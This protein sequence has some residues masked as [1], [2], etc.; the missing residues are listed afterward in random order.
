MKVIKYLISI[1]FILST[2]I[3]CGQDELE[4]KLDSIEEL[5]NSETFNEDYKPILQAK[6]SSYKKCL[7]EE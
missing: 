2:N 6:E 3:V 5:V 4:I 7:R 1:L